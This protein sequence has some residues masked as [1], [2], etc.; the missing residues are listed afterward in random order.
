MKQ[1]YQFPILVVAVLLVVS[2]GLTVLAARTRA[3]T[4]P[5]PAP[6]ASLSAPR[7]SARTVGAR[8]TSAPP[9]PIA[10]MV[11]NLPGSAR[12]QL[13]LDRADIVY[14]MLVEGGITRFLAVYQGDE[15]VTVEPVRSVRTPFLYP[16]KELGAV[17][18]HVGG[19]ETANEADAMG[20]LDQW[21]VRHLDEAADPDLF[22]R[23]P[24]RR[25]PHNTLT[26]TAALQAEAAARRWTAP[27]AAAWPS[28]S[29]KVAVNAVTDEAGTVRFSWAPFE[30]LE[31]DVDWTYDQE[32]NAYR[33]NQG[34]SPHVD[35]RT[36]EQLT[37]K[38]VIVQFD[39]ARVV[40][41][42][43][44][45]VY[46][47]VGEGEAYIFLDGQLIEA[48]WTKRT[49]EERTRYHDASGREI[50]LNQG[51]TWIAVLPVGAPLTW[52]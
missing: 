29:D 22:P 38:N 8:A 42:E 37:A 39:Q 27:P 34:G 46:G 47:S 45:V 17:I 5:A 16:A 20:Q 43:G 50:R 11:D 41:R 19:A 4:P 32:S 23:D 44:H 10:V 26:D 40:D 33:R 35:G 28:K 49:R 7:T 25:A 52:R 3:A 1:R 18:A 21:G 2:T 51:A 48:R 31:F 13:G 30:L 36:G 9:V 24:A 14:E 6:D 15:P 12:P